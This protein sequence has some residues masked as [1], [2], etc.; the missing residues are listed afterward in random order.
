MYTKGIYRN[1]DTINNVFIC[2]NKNEYHILIG[3]GY[4]ITSAYYTN[5]LESKC[6]NNRDAQNLFKIV[7]T[8]LN[9][10]TNK[11]AQAVPFVL[12]TASIYEFTIKK[13]NCQVM[14]YNGELAG[15]NIES[16][17]CTLELEYDSSLNDKLFY[18][19]IAGLVYTELKSETLK[20]NNEEEDDI[21]TRSLEEIGLD[22]DITWLKDKKYYIVNDDATA[23]QIL[24]I[25]DNSNCVIAYDTETTGLRINV[26]GKINSKYQKQLKE[27]NKNKP[28]SEQIQA[29]SLV[30]IIF[31]VE[32]NVS[33]YFPVG[34]KKFKNL[35]ETDTPIRKSL[36]KNFKA[37]YTIGKYRDLD[38]D[39][40][41]YWRKTPEN[42]IT[43]DVILMER[44]RNILTTKHLVAHNGSFEWKVSYLY[45]IVINL[46]DDTM[47]M[48]QL[49]YKFRSTTSNRG[50]PS[51]LKYLTKRELG[52][53]QLDLHDFFVNYKEDKDGLIK[54]GKKRAKIDFSYM[55]YAGSKAYAP[56]D[57]DTTLQI[58]KK[59]KKDLIENHKDLVY[60][61]Q[62]EIIV[63]SAIG[64]MEFY[65][66]KLDEEKIND[67][68]EDKKTEL[69]EL[70]L[71]FRKSVK[72][73]TTKEEEMR[74]E[75]DLLKESLS[76]ITKQE[77]EQEDKLRASKHQLIKT[78]DNKDIQNRVT[79]IENDMA[80][81]KDC[82]YKKQQE[83]CVY[84]DK[85]R[86]YIDSSEK[87]INLGSPAQVADLLFGE[88]G[89]ECPEEK[90]S[91]NKK[92]IK[93]LKKYKNDDKS[94]KYPM[95]ALYSDWKNTSTLITK[96]FDKLPQ[97]MFPGGFIFSSFGQISCAT[98]RMSCS[99]PN[100]QQ[101]TK[102]VTSLI[103]P[104]D[105]N[106]MI[107]ADFSQI[108]Y[109]TLVAMANEQSL[110]EKFFD[111]DND[112]H[113]TMASLMFG[114]P[115][116][117]VTKQMRSDAKSF[118]F[119]IPYGMGF[120]S[121]AILLTGMGDKAHQEE[122]KEKYELYFKDQP[123]V[124]AFFNRVKEGA[125]VYK[126]TKTLFNRRRDYSFT[127]EDGTVSQER[128]AYAQRQAG[129]ACIQGCL[130]GD[131]LIQTK[132]FGIVKIKD[133]VNKSILVWDGDKW[134][135]GDVLYSGKKQK[136]IVTFNNGQ[137]FI[138][139]PTHKFLV[140][141]GRGNERFVECQNLISK[142]NGTNPHRVVINRQYEPSDFKYSSDW[143]YK[144]K[145]KV[146]NAHN[147]FIGDIGN[148]FKMGVFLGRLTSDGSYA[149]LDES[150]S[151]VVQII[152]EHEF[153]IL[154][155]LRDC[156]RNLGYTEKNDDVRVDRNE[157][158][159]RL[160]VYSK[161]LV[162][163]LNDLDTRH[164][165]DSRLL[166]DTE[167]LRGYLRGMFDGDGGIGGQSIVLT[168]GK[169]YNFEPLC[170]AIQKILLFFGIRGRYY[171]HLD[172]YKIVI[173]LADNQ[174]FLDIIG[175]MNKNKQAK[176]RATKS[177]KDGHIFKEV[178]LVKSVEIT[179]EY[180]D[181]YDVCNTDGGY[182]VADG[183]ITHNT[184]ADIFKISV[185]RNFNFIKEN[186]LFGK[187]LIVNMIHDEQLMEIDCN[188][189][190]PLVCFKNII[191]NMQFKID[192]FPPL[193]VGAGLGFNWKYAKGGDAEIHPHLSEKLCKEAENYSLFV[194]KPLS[195][196]D[197]FNY[198]Q[199]QV[200]NFRLNKVKDYLCD[201]NNWGKQIHPVIGSLLTGDFTYGLKQ[202]KV[203]DEPDDPNNEKDEDYVMRLLGQFIEKNG[204]PVKVEYFK[205]NS[206]SKEEE[207][208]T[209]YFDDEE[210][211]DDYEISGSDFALIDEDPSLFGSSIVD[212]INQFGYFVSVNQRVCGI[213][214]AHI[215]KKRLAQLSE[216]ISTKVVDPSEKDSMEVCFLKEGNLLLRTG[217]Y[218]ANIDAVNIKNAVGV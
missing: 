91:V 3:Q 56:A 51:N 43:P 171:E 31:C 206:T 40:A 148:S 27:Y 194:D 182:Y 94:L 42:E 186:N 100:L 5:G 12:G 190:N 173:T 156:M 45:D 29:D 57:G 135:M 85:I 74:K 78:P 81:I 189:L 35:Y 201:K 99:K 117:A 8:A 65:G 23:E 188:T 214:V 158:L 203:S 183:I 137:K 102:A 124:R 10:C 98:G 103:I 73:S 142:Q 202:I 184:A 211:E 166:M 160:S 67:V 39:M 176:G 28:K 138:C 152:A 80:N 215:S 180:I 107:D 38:T 58:F 30:G 119:G 16:E 207:E 175:F 217:L 140:R 62:I 179:D 54:G 96:F 212:L 128:K 149:R 177:A 52:I 20:I 48:H 60:L 61:Y 106:I 218:V 18:G 129:N 41:R 32:D 159:T 209:E 170:R 116:A 87:T 77:R 204:L 83:I 4:N 143:A 144:Y 123:N 205:A 132:D 68:C 93:T 13:M 172:R 111:P 82:K 120:K 139:S 7:K 130:H 161:S 167:L 36:I 199:S 133:V 90:R 155:E 71:D 125:L 47:I 1:N 153:N 126:Y 118:N 114:V 46:C 213:N 185:A 22:K 105:N 15:C 72:Y 14:R 89:I 187:M 197:V 34:N 66:V 208:D 70:E 168:F 122:A 181:M 24:S 178:L 145:S 198:F 95:V 19:M 146:H 17:E 37:Q 136:C 49:M 53:D 200:D 121:L 112:Y 115:Y 6:Y 141:N 50:E 134:S 92:I 101:M 163:E 196:L 150:S 44:C 97:F 108:E 9:K 192:G 151:R 147:V 88:L 113:T 21:P 174:K 191:N 165:L 131:T 162:R 210:D 157:T 59:Y 86:E 195:S 193:Y 11:N 164:Q 127:N 2:H 55:D 169:Q 216:Y 25:L 69:L 110:I 76:D 63:A 75:L 79:S 109:R 33:Y 26:F 154:P 84:R 64:Y 104:R